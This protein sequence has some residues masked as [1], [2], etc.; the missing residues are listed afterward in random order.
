MIKQKVDYR[1]M[2]SAETTTG[3]GRLRLDLDAFS[4]IGHVVIL[5]LI[6]IVTVGIGV[7][8]PLRRREA[9]TEFNRDQR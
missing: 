9:D 3:L 8:F 5:T 6:A 4:V 1:P 7:I 2:H